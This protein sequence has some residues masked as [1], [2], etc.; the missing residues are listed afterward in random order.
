MKKKFQ[1]SVKTFHIIIAISLLVSS[2]SLAATTNCETPAIVG[3]KGLFSIQFSWNT[4]SFAK[5]MLVNVEYKKKGLLNKKKSNGGTF[6]TAGRDRFINIELTPGDYDFFAVTAQYDP[7]IPKGKYLKIPME[8]SFSI[9]AGEVTNGGMIFLV[10]ENKQSF[11]IMTLKVDNT[12]DVKR[13]VHTYKND[14]TGQIN[15]AWDYLPKEKMDKMVNSFAAVLIERESTAK[16]PRV[17]YTYSTLG[18]V[19]KMEKDSTGKVVDYKL[20]PTGTYQKI[21]K[22]SLKKDG[23]ILCVLENNNYLYGDEDNLPFMPLPKTLASSPELHEL[24]DSTFLMLDRN[25]NIYTANKSFNWK[26]HLQFSEEYD[27]SFFQARTT[28]TKVYKGKDNL[29]IYTTGIGK[30]RLL[31]KSTYD[32]FN[33]TQVELSKDIKKVPMVTE[34]TNQLIIGPVMKL[35]VSAKRPAYIYVK[36]RNDN[37]WE[38]LPLPFGDCFGFAPDRKD[39]TV[40]FTKCTESQWHKS[41]DGGKTWEKYQTKAVSDTSN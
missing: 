41:I 36:D 9:K 23:N 3:N 27:E 6:F 38:E 24:N 13:Y 21:Q 29:Y 26:E 7:S 25:R 32:D 2:F 11:N 14:Y 22:M 20:I 15:P 39:D 10:R 8:G 30:N 17:K 18:I 5:N 19:L 4:D 31:L 33:F 37:N 40:F 34:T 1:H 35:N 12:E 16:R 28:K